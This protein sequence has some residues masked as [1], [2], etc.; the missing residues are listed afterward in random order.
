MHSGLRA[1]LT[2]VQCGRAPALA[3][4]SREQA[5]AQGRT[6]RVTYGRSS[7]V[8]FAS[9]ALQ[10]SLESR[11]RVGLAGRGCPLFAL[12]WKHWRIA[13]QVPICAVR[14]WAHSTSGSDSGSSR[15]NKSGWPTTTREDGRSS[16]RHGYMVQGKPGTTLLDA[17]RL[18]A[19]ATPNARDWK[20]ETTTT[21][22]AV[23]RFQHRRGKSLSA[24]ATLTRGTGASGCTVAT[25]SGGLLNPAHSRW[26]QGFPAEW[27]GCAHMAMRSSR[28]SPLPLSA[29]MSRQPACNTKEDRS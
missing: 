5:R 18:A 28:T 15:I 22:F 24:E 21:A 12:T 20:S 19:W 25:T 9:A 27:D 6:T 3:S 14:A 2:T 26:L 11:L 17:A 29:P 1:G 13:Q 8:S 7:A 23:E 10:S 16:A 4:R